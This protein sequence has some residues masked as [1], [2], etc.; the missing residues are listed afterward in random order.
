MGDRRKNIAVYMA[1]WNDNICKIILTGIFQRA[2]EG[3]CNVSVINCY[4][5]IDST[6]PN[7][8][9]EYNMFDL[10]IE[11][12]FDGAIVISNIILSQKAKRKII[13]K[14]T[15]A[16]IPAVFLEE[17]VP[18]M[19]FVGIDNYAAMKEVVE[20]LIVKHGFKKID[21]V[22][23]PPNSVEG[24]ERLMAYKDALREHG[25]KVESERIFIGLFNYDSG[26]DAGRKI[27]SANRELPEAVVCAN[28]EMA[29]AVCEV[30]RAIRIKVPGQVAVVGFDNIDDA[31]S[32]APRITSVGRPMLDMG[33]IAC[34]Q[35]ISRMAG[36][37][38]SNKI[39]LNAKC[40]F[41]ESCGCM[42]NSEVT[43]EDF[44]HDHYYTKYHQ[45]VFNKKTQKM[46]EEL[47]NC[48]NLEEHME[49]V[50]NYI[51][52]LESNIF[53][54]CVNATDF[55]KKRDDDAVK[56]LVLRENYRIKGY[57]DNMK[58]LYAYEGGVSV[59]YPNFPTKDVF[60]FPLQESEFPRMFEFSPIHFLDKSIGYL[61][62]ENSIFIEARDLYY[63]WLVN[64]NNSFENVWH[65]EQLS[66]AVDLLNEMYVRDSMTKLYNRFGFIKYASSLYDMARLKEKTFMI[67]LIDIDNL[68]G[69]NSISGYEQGDFVI[70]VV[71]NVLHLQCPSEGITVRFGGD[72]F[73]IVAADVS[74]ERAKQLSQV[75]NAELKEFS[76][77]HELQ[78]L[79]E[80][81]IG[82]YIMRCD[83]K[84]SLEDCMKNADARMHDTKNNK[85]A[86]DRGGKA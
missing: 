19:D 4:A 69:I 59:S 72:E 49:C 76:E 26:I 12:I 30:F 5:G 80:V 77:K 56:R 63:L 39:V 53:F 37:A 6:S 43:Y 79:L 65:K 85:S 51:P 3:D 7:S 46:S 78:Y 36:T 55:E 62:T 20:H 41:T 45:Y 68:R 61:I 13:K 15:E 64:L 48:E 34:D 71:G 38:V 17:A 60:P 67:M 47:T 81:S 22:T 66:M 31:Q 35:I 14:I 16:G 58:V 86:G 24:N 74:E 70:K 52:L 84:I 23:G 9:G 33:Y 75:I 32:Y 11:G 18:D 54:L 82:Y 83:E 57:D 73:V 27:C 50:K 29:M 40:N 21:F 1:G 28:D 8:V 44:R 42:Q 2:K 25:L 10:P